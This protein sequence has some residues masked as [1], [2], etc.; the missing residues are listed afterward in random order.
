MKSAG[1]A[2]TAVVTGAAG[3]LG[4]ALTVALARRGRV[5]AIDRRAPARALR[6]SAP[7]A[8][9]HVADIADA[10]RLNRIF[11]G[12]RVGGGAPC[13][14]LHFA[15]FYHFGSDERPEYAETNLRGTANVLAATRAA[16]ARR[17]LF[18]SSLAALE[19]PAGGGVLEEDCPALGGSPYGRSKARGEALARA[20]SDA[21]PAA[22]LRIGGAF[23]DDCNLP[24]LH[25][26]MRMWRGTGFVSRALVGRGETA[27]PFIHRDD[28]VALALRALDRHAA[29]DRC[30]TLHACSDRA[31]PH[32]ELF[33]AMQAAMGCR[34]QPWHVP[35][36]CA[37]AGLHARCACGALLGRMPFER[38]WM[39]DYV[40][41]P[42]R[43]GT[44]RTRAAL[45][46]ACRPEREV[47]AKMPELVRRMQADPE[48]WDW[49]N[50]E[51]NEARFTYEPEKSL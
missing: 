41:R 6:A 9:W 28:L 16:G 12:V 3:F 10:E 46:W 25:S 49:R 1:A 22:V 7:E 50:L 13:D 44:A 23:N 2:P 26:L 36:W 8:E 29:L 27:I 31:V 37:R 39:L 42:W 32:A 35:V 24:P 15:A 14:V 17:V 48:G 47:L 43:I 4:S 33:A 38:P 21:L 51:R 34:V 45:F 30:V 11:A 40:D 19:L 18:A 5:I 20:A